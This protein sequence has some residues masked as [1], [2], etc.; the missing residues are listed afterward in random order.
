MEEAGIKLSFSKK[1]LEET[2]T[3]PKTLNVKFGDAYWILKFEHDIITLERVVEPISVTERDIF[4]AITRGRLNI[5]PTFYEKLL[6][7]INKTDIIGDRYRDGIVFGGRDLTM[8]YF[9]AS[10]LVEE[11]GYYDVGNTKDTVLRIEGELNGD[12]IV[13]ELSS[14]LKNYCGID[15]NEFDVP[16]LRKII[17]EDSFFFESFDDTKYYG[18]NSIN[19]YVSY[20]S[21]RGIVYI[22]RVEVYND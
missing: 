15:F 7:L 11:I 4:K 9:G 10:G 8:E 13:E 17:E 21:G 2:Q 19:V 12:S 18:K 1:F 6:T 5:T 22:I 14:L 3:K 16:K 20:S